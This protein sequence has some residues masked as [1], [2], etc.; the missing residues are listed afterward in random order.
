MTEPIKF[1]R[2]GEIA[3]RLG[4]PDRKIHYTLRKYRIKPA[5]V[6]TILSLNGPRSRAGF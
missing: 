1:L 2:A 4:M 5:A 3:S 6:L